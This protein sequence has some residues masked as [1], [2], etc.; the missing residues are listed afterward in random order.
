LETPSGN[1]LAHRENR[2]TLASRDVLN[3]L[4]DLEFPVE[5]QDRLEAELA[6][7]D[8]VSLQKLF[9]VDYF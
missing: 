7:E 8:C 1:D 3:A 2:K 4:K 5:W 9:D 6:S